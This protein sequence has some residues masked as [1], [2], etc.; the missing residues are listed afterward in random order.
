MNTTRRRRLYT[1]LLALLGLGLVIGLVMYALRDNISLYY[2]PS[3]LY[4][5]HFSLRQKLRLG[6]MV[7]NGSVK[8]QPNSLKVSFVLTDFHQQVPVRYQGIL[9][10]LFREGQGIVAEGYLRGRTFIAEQVLAK[11]DESY[12]PPGIP[13][14]PRA[15][16]G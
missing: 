2:T 16:K 7:V 13:N 12:H 5:H 10:A 4:S 14:Q 15:S 6:G 3:Q 8:H 11:H 9:P 1:I